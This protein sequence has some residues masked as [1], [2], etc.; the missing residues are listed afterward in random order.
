MMRLISNR[1]SPID[2][3]ASIYLESYEEGTKEIFYKIK[4]TSK[5]EIDPYDYGKQINNMLKHKSILELRV[6]IRGNDK[7]EVYNKIY[8]VISNLF[9]DN[10]VFFIVLF[11]EKTDKK[12]IF[13][14]LFYSKNDYLIQDTKTIKRNI[15]FNLD[16]I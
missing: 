14:I 7:M 5:E 6:D 8:T 10:D 1:Q 9:M 15:R 4:V 2:Y 16:K 3:N 12:L 11:R 13:D